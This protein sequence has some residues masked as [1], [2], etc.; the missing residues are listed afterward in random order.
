MKMDDMFG[1]K[2]AAAALESKSVNG[3]ENKEDA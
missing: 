3:E 2:T 1:A